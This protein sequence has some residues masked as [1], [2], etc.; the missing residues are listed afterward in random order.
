MEYEL[1]PKPS[2]KKTFKSIDELFTEKDA[3]LEINQLLI[4]L[5]Y[6]RNNKRSLT[7]EEV[8][9]AI[10]LEKEDCTFLLIKLT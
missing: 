5:L 1:Y 9:N 10:S 3:E 4:R 6:I 8:K 7:T 2:L